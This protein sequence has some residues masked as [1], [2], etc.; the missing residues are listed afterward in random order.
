MSNM[1]YCR[2]QNTLQDL[3]DCSNVMEET[4]D[5]SIDECNARQSLL[6]LCEEITEAAE[7]WKGTGYNKEHFACDC[8]QCKR[9][10]KEANRS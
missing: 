3:R 10:A 5:L 8:A 2:F 4:E 1:S 6:R 9:N 7:M